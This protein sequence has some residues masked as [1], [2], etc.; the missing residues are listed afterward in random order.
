MALF[1]LRQG[2]EVDVLNA[3]ELTAQID[4]LVKALEAPAKPRWLRV[5]AVTDGV[6]DDPV[7]QQS[8]TWDVL[9]V[10]QGQEFR[11]Q[12]L[13][14]R[15]TANLR[16]FSGEGVFVEVLRDGLVVDVG[17]GKVNGSDPNQGTALPLRIVNPAGAGPVFRN[18]E[19]LQ[20]RIETLGAAAISFPAPALAVVEGTLHLGAA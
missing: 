6:A 5:T 11:M 9:R 16:N 12:R 20:V 19:L 3:A 4:R 13:V 18:G 1:R 15:P 8:V 17:V 2:A 7:L 10:Q 14:V